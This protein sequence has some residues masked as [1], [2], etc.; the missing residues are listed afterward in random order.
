MDSSSSQAI[1][2]VPDTSIISG[3]LE[4]TYGAARGAC[5]GSAETQE[6]RRFPPARSRWIEFQP[7]IARD[8]AIGKDTWERDSDGHD[9]S[10]AI[11]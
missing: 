5:V 9:A 4:W 2:H 3:D 1:A 8:S 10:E 6:K 7:S 11:R